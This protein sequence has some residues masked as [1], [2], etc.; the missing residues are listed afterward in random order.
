V[1]QNLPDQLRLLD[2]GNDPQP[3]AAIRAG[4]DIDKVN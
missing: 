4:F 3:A 2:A 1:L